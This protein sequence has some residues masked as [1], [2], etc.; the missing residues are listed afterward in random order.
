MAC[1]VAY[2]SKFNNV[3]TCILWLTM[4]CYGDQSF[5][6]SRDFWWLS[7]YHNHTLRLAY[8]QSKTSTYTL[9]GWM[10]LQTQ[11]PASSLPL[12]LFLPLDP[13]A[14]H[15]YHQHPPSSSTSSPAPNHP[16]LRQTI[17]SVGKPDTDTDTRTHPPS[18]LHGD[19]CYDY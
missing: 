3:M 11:S 4:T 14:H 9:N 16:P 1:A 19:Y 13:T 17:L 8:K 7:E 6:Q 10:Y 15:H 5:D 2:K 12:P 18:P